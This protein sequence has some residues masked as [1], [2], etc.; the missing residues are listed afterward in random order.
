MA[1]R[2]APGEHVDEILRA[3]QRV[4]QPEV[5]PHPLLHARDHDEVPLAPGS[6]GRG[7]QSHRLG[8]V[9]VRRESV[10]GQVLGLQVLEERGRG[11]LR[12][13][14]DEPLGRG[15]EREHGV[16]VPVAARTRGPATQRGPAPRLGKTRRRPQRPQDVE[17]GRARACD[18]LPTGRE[19]PC[20]PLHSAPD[21]RRERRGPLRPG[22][23]LHEQWVAR[24]DPAAGD[25]LRPERSAQTA[26]ADGVQ[27]TE[28]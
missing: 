25:L 20:D 22:Q 24:P 28:R 17:R 21:R 3:E 11:G 16:E 6:A 10:R 15:E 2:A 1:A 5:G 14:V 7:E 23:G 9:A 27:P 8:E 4:A 19:H 12:H 26:Q 13:P 18:G